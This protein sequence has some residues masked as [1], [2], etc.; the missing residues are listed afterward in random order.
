MCTSTFLHFILYEK[1]ITGKAGS[2]YFFSS[3]LDITKRVKFLS[4][5]KPII[6]AMAPPTAAAM[7]M[8]RVLSTSFTA[9]PKDH[10]HKSKFPR[11][12]SARAKM[13]QLCSL[14]LKCIFFYIL[15]WFG[16]ITHVLL[17]VNEVF[18]ERCCSVNI[19]QVHKY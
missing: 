15:N 13:P 11:V 1:Q 2:T 3:S 6:N 12:S 9:M 7:M 19:L 14:S 18:L 16:H 4:S 8:V 5:M 17:G 10:H